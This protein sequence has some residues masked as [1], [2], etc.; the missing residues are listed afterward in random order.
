MEHSPIRPW[1]L[2]LGTVVALMLHH[3]HFQAAPP[4]G[5][6]LAW[7]Q[8]ALL[9]VS[10][11]LSVLASYLL[12]PDEPGLKDTKPTTQV[13]RGAFI[14]WH[15]GIRRL[16]PIVGWVGRRTSFKL[17]G[18][19]RTY[20]EGGWHI[21]CVGPCQVLHRIIDSG[22]V[23]FNGPINNIS[24]PSGS[25]IDL[26]NEGGFYIHWGEPN[27]NVN[28]VLP[29]QIGVNSRWPYHCYIMWWQKN[30][31][32]AAQWGQ[33]EYDFEKKIQNSNLSNSNDNFAAV[34][35]ILANNSFKV[36]IHETGGPDDRY[37]IGGNHAA[38]FPAGTT[39]HIQ[40]AMTGP[41]EERGGVYFDQTLVTVANAIYSAGPDTTQIFFPDGSLSG[42]TGSA[43]NR[44]LL[45][46]DQAQYDEALAKGY[47][48]S[49]HETGGLTDRL[50]VEGNVASL[51]YPGR[52]VRLFSADPNFP[53]LD[54]NVLSSNAV[55]GNETQITFA[56]GSLSPGPDH[57][58]LYLFEDEEDAGVNL[59]HAFD[60]MLHGPWPQGLNLPISGTFQAFDLDSL[61]DLGVLVGDTGEALR[62]SLLAKNGEKVQSVF[63][64]ALQDAGVF[65]PMDPSTGLIKFVPIREP[66]GVIP[67]VRNE[68]IVDEMPEVEVLHIERPADRI[69]FTFP[70]RTLFDR[71]G[72][73]AVMDDGQISR[74]ETQRA[75]KVQ[76]TITGDYRT[77]S[78]IAQR[79]SQ[80]LLAGGSAIKVRTNRGTRKLVP[81][82]AVDFDALPEQM[83]VLTTKLDPGSNVVFLTL[84][85]HFMGIP[86]TPFED[87]NENISEEVAAAVPDAF[88]AIFELSEFQIGAQAQTVALPRIR[89]HDQIGSAAL[90]LSVD[91][92][93]Y[94]QVGQEF[95]LQ[96]GGLL[97]D[98]LPS[99]TLTLLENGPVIIAQGPDISQVLDLSGDVVNW[100]LG[101]QLCVFI[102]S[103][104]TEICF[105]RNVTAL[106]GDRYRLDGLIRARYET[107]QLDH[108]VLN[109][110]TEV[111][112]FELTNIEQ[113]QDLLLTPQSLLYAKTQPSGNGT[114]S[115]SEVFPESTVLYG[116]GINGRPVPP[117]TLSVTAPDL[118]SA[119]QTGDDVSFQWT[120]ATP[121]ATSAS[122]G[123]QGA[124][125]A[126]GVV[127]PD[128]DF[129][130]E[131][132]DLTGTTV[133]R[134]EPLASNTYTYDNADLVADHGGEP[135]FQ[136]WVYQR[137]N[138]LLSDPIKL[139][140]ERI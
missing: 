93:T 105:L 82:Q 106:G 67:R 71:E 20:F 70:D 79:R 6:Q 41:S 56:D 109:A 83:L 65:V 37:T 132:R 100:R 31:G 85:A 95:D 59:A 125:A 99:D 54:L 18:E 138:G 38:L 116:K 97:E 89:A 45:W 36:L 58:V 122:S 119:Y 12:A 135:S 102:S 60:R 75:R 8:V 4:E 126:M 117:G 42:G 24:H 27:Q 124:G 80:E 104:G 131:V 26:G 113:I 96:T 123:L 91:D 81:G 130:L 21:V 94:T 78:V 110:D 34:S 43:A 108:A 7:V 128:G 1:H 3:H 25:R 88:A 76:I 137:R 28:T 66:S 87:L 68:L 73:I 35:T 23:V 13:F 111:Y 62:C 69:T 29:G 46:L 63:G 53:D 5:P 90:H 98:D 74:E 49:L 40:H 22:R 57:G 72:T 14:N 64:T 107:R 9:I 11:A 32:P 121:Q 19:T 47:R 15:L 51:F 55:S 140:V 44:A 118:V 129:V 115:L 61:E 101:R 50:T 127:P 39:V 103:S 136:V 33:I 84:M 92:V 114:V 112:I 120:Y 52:L 139:T 48:V 77:A 16:G 17:D 30:V 133:V 86:K 2:T 134:S 10:V